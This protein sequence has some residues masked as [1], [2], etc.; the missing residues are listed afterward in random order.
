MEKITTGQ[1]A[2]MIAMFAKKLPFDMP[3]AIAQKWI[4]DPDSF[5]STI[6]LALGANDTSCSDS[7]DQIDGWKTFYKKFFN[8]D[9]DMTGVKI[10]AKVEGFDRLI[11]VAKGVSINQVYEIGK[12]NFPSWKWCDGDIESQMQASERGKVK[13]TYAIWVHDE[14]EADKDLL[15][16]SAEDIKNPQDTENLLERLLHGFKYWSETGEH[17]DRKTYTLCVASRYSAGDVP[18]VNRYDDGDVSV[19]R[20]NPQIRNAFIGARRAV[21]VG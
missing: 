14:Q 2:E 18:Y 10:P 16:K 4:D 15:G 21:R 8:I 7:S 1:V 19:G 6:A 3:K 17:L 11:I 20:F 5:E 13:E 12:K 9:L